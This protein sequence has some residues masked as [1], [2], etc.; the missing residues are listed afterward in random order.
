MMSSLIPNKITVNQYNESVDT[1]QYPTNVVEL[2]EMLEDLA[3][4]VWKYRY[5]SGDVDTDEAVRN[6]RKLTGVLY[7]Y[8]WLHGEEWSVKL[9]EDGVINTMVDSKLQV[10]GC[11]YNK[12]Q[13]S[14]E[15]PDGKE[16]LKKEVSSLSHRLADYQ[17]SKHKF[18]E[19]DQSIQIY[20]RLAGLLNHLELEHD[21]RWWVIFEKEG[22]VFVSGGEV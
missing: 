21:R 13:F 6:Y 14:F 5:G 17:T 4:N 22:P 3:D 19:T 2:H 20:Q 1:Y 8:E 11:E 15:F 9:S 7:E 10:R 12:N 18:N 16:E